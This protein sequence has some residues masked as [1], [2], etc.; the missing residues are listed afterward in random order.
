MSFLNL[1]RR[2]KSG[3]S[4]GLAFR[5]FELESLEDRCLLSVNPVFAGSAP[6]LAA[7]SPAA[8]GD[9]DVLIQIGDTITGLTED[10]YATVSL[11]EGHTINNV[12]VQIDA[13][14]ANEYQNSLILDN[15]GTIGA[16]NFQTASSV[17]RTLQTYWPTIM[18]TTPVPTE[19]ELYYYYYDGETAAS[20]P[21]DTGSDGN[22]TAFLTI[23]QSSDARSQLLA[24]QI[25]ARMKG[26]HEV[27]D[28]TLL[29]AGNSESGVINEGLDKLWGFGKAV[30]FENH[31]TIACDVD[32]TDGQGAD[33]FLNNGG[34]MQGFASGSTDD[35]FVTGGGS[36]SGDVNVGAGNDRVTVF[37]TT[38]FAGGIEFG[39]GDDSL[40]LY[41]SAP[42]DAGTV[43]SADLL[44]VPEQIVI[45]DVPLIGNFETT[46]TIDTELPDTEVI[47]DFSL[48]EADA[49]GE[50]GVAL[51]D[52]AN[53]TAI[54]AYTVLLDADTVLGNGS[55]KVIIFS[56]AT[57]NN[58]DLNA[59]F[60]F[61][62]GEK[63]SASF[64]DVT[65]VIDGTDTLVIN[66]VY[67]YSL[68]YDGD[69]IY[70]QRTSSQGKADLVTVSVTAVDKYTGEDLDI[71]GGVLDPSNVA[72]VTVTFENIG[73]AAVA[74]AYFYSAVRLK[75]ADTGEYI[76]L[77]PG[78]DWYE[79]YSVGG[80]DVG[81]TGSFSFLLP[82]LAVGNYT[83]EIQLNSR[84]TVDELNYDDDY[85]E[86][87]FSVGLHGSDLVVTIDSFS[88][89]DE[90]TGEVLDIYNGG[91]DT[92]NNARVT[93]TF[94]NIGEEDVDITWPS[95]NTYFYNEVLV[96]DEA[97]NIIVMSDGRW[98]ERIVVPGF[99][100]A[101]GGES[102]FDFLLPQLEVGK[103]YI[104]VVLDHRLVTNDI[105]RSNNTITFE[106]EVTEHVD[107]YALELVDAVAT[108]R[109]TGDVV[110]LVDGVEIESEVNDVVVTFKN[111]SG[112]DID[113]PYVYGGVKLQDSEG[114][115]ILGS[116][117]GW[118][119]RLSYEGRG[120]DETGTFKFTV[121][122]L[123]AGDYTL[124]LAIDQRAA[125]GDVGDFQTINFTVK[126][127]EA[128]KADLA[129][130]GISA[131]DKISGN[132][133]NLNAVLPTQIPVFTVTYA[134]LGAAIDAPYFYSSVQ[135]VKS[136]GT[137]V[138]DTYE[139][140]CKTGLGAGETGSFNFTIG[141]QA[142]GTYT[143]K[144]QLD[145]REAI[146][147]IS[148]EN[149]YIEYTFEVVN[150]E[151]AELPEVFADE[152]FVDDLFVE[153]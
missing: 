42:G 98:Y 38:D 72:N 12:T 135:V 141:K 86:V 40:T 110:E 66:G 90:F 53:L 125:I 11:A 118:Y 138:L 137:V 63:S 33:Y 1:F 45:Y 55:D 56:G 4:A 152:S 69:N 61:I 104:D 124:T 117:D 133:L 18:G 71:N 35:G 127:E 94:W 39:D 32:S 29:V 14:I 130:T 132:D 37:D 10:T 73:D 128:P 47:I 149:D 70:L 67:E 102:S 105:D 113:A 22:I 108:G 34:S 85:S 52:A 76:T 114:N 30:L 41:G 82:R 2:A 9:E 151:G 109:S 43:F 96:Y 20:N 60:T 100:A 79:R 95:G 119:E 81:E 31:G 74:D 28:V 140:L 139:R 103:Y 5:R 92:T 51:G 83:I 64:D 49:Y 120:E 122:A 21:F 144:V 44:D 77:N 48:V 65:L 134:N 80:E 3:L 121:K 58:V 146:D 150:L 126:G 24:N 112:K 16:F 101:E 6:A 87:N 147:Q 145:N 17:Y 106:F 23:L 99:V 27:A 7:D 57:P 93:V 148:R 115:Y 88:A 54:G 107:V 19:Q 68:L 153:F 75:N 26:M 91:I 59:E 46:V 136:D 50:Y 97:G 84:G 129:N 36:V 89:V 123:E 62:N 142:V 131:I 78:K 143:V 8:T 15:S 13:Y 25:I 111:V 116:A